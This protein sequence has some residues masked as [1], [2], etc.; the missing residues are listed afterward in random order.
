MCNQK[1]TD[2]K[3]R[4]ESKN[5]SILLFY[6]GIRSSVH[7]YSRHIIEIIS[8]LL[9]QRVIKYSFHTSNTLLFS[10]NASS[11]HEVS[12]SS[13]KK[14]QKISSRVGKILR[15]NES[16][17]RRR[18]SSSSHRLQILTT[19]RFECYSADN[20]FESVVLRVQLFFFFFFWKK[21]RRR[22]KRKEENDDHHFFP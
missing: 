1:K 21:G 18:L 11:R 13:S 16:R 17:E 22:R 10:R 4:K 7:S 9:S 14:I 2:K 15:F 12:L 6:V 8:K 19:T 5:I 3:K 20:I